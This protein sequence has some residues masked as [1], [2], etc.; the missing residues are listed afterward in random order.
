MKPLRTF[1]TEEQIEALATRSYFRYG[2]QIAEA[3]DVKVLKTNTFNIVARVQHAK[4]EARTVELMSTPKGFRYRCTC[5][6]RK[7][8]F[9]QHCVAVGLAALK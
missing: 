8:L 6:S 7:N 4:G 9:C 1:L 2:K 5:S 3:G